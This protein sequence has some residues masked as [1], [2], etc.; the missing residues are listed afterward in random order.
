MRR[1]AA[2]VVLTV[3]VVAGHPAG[4]QSPTKPVGV[5]SHVKVLSN[6]VKDVSS[7]AAWKKSFIRDSMTPREKA[8]ACWETVVRFQ[9]QDSPPAEYLQNENTVLDA[10]KLFNV[11]G[12][13]FCGVAASHVQSLARHVGLEA[14]GWT[15]RGHVVPEVKWDGK[16][17]LLDASLINYFPKPDG[18]LASIAEIKQAVTD[19]LKK[20]PDYASGGK[21]I[22]AKLRTFHK[23]NGWT[24]WK[25]GPALLTKCPFY[26]WGGWL[27]ART[28][29]WYS[30]MQEYDGSTLFPYECGYSQ[31]YQVNVQLRPGERLTRNWSHKGLHVNRADGGAPGCLKG[32]ATN[33]FLKYTR[34]YGDRTEGRVGNGVRE[35]D[36]PLADGAFRTGAL[37]AENLAC[38]GEAKAGPAVHVKDASQPGLLEIRMPSSYVYLTGTVT[39]QAVVGSGGKIA[40]LLSD[41][42]GLD[43][44]PLASVEAT[45][46]RTVDLTPRVLRRYDYRLRFVMKG[47]GTGLD[48]LKILHDVQHSQRPLPI[49]GQGKNTITFTAGPQE[50]TI[51]IEGST[52]PKNKSKQLVTADFHPK[53]N[54]IDPLLMRMKAGKADITFS[55]KTPGDMTR[56]RFGC[57]YRARGA[58][59]AWDLQVSFDEGKT[60]RTV[61]TA[62]GPKVFGAKYV[63]F[64]DVPAATRA[65]LVRYAGRQRNTMCMFDFRIDAD[66]KEPHGGF[67]P[68]KVT[69]VWEEGGLEK[70]HVHVARK[71]LETYEIQCPSTPVMKSL[72]LELAE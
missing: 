22:D 15:I 34:K 48:G 49:L 53:M 2:L 71:P 29:G 66:Y 63:T 61:A 69:Y 19:W 23:A 50:G 45:G 11:Y 10:I 28:H 8:L 52:N 30:T 70:R 64:S 9:H 18:D 65:A 40:V 21:G 56:L 1:L 62:K 67:R 7:M 12:Y 37:R 36:V 32:H 5:V 46:K 27:P 58:R 4:G 38:K 6:R 16:W 51:T 72:L 3:L 41:N 60:F 42:H 33:S 31:G 25:R 13:S 68:V 47:K 26:D 54:Q 20:N 59:D 44:A 24:G 55:V 17:H 57:F 39:F 43:W 14:R 35:Y